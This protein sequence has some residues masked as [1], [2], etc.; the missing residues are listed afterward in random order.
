MKAAPIKKYQI[1][2]N[3]TEHLLRFSHRICVSNGNL[4]YVEAVKPL[5][6]CFKE[7]NSYTKRDQVSKRVIPPKLTLFSL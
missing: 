2:I 7:S 1:Y 5:R 3:E 6:A 4:G